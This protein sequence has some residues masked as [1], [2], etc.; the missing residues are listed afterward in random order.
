MAQ[1]AVTPQA[2]G[3]VQK[4]KGPSAPGLFLMKVCETKALVHP[5]GTRIIPGGPSGKDETELPFAVIE[6][7]KNE[8]LMRAVE[9]VPAS[10]NGI[11]GT[12]AHL[13][14]Y[15]MSAISVVP[16]KLLS[17]FTFRVEIAKMSCLE[18]SRCVHHLSTR[19][20]ERSGIL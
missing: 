9:G 19:R 3:N 7:D 12:R 10:G 5:N 17:Q 2:E 13:Y 6:M 4:V 14:V 1:M 20:L 15:L 16:V 11:W 18:Q 8:V